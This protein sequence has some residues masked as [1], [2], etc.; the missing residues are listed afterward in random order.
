[1]NV[2]E[3]I[4]QAKRLEIKDNPFSSNGVVERRDVRSLKAALSNPGVSVIA[5]IKMKSPSEGDILPGA[6]PVQIAIDYESAGATAISVLTDTQFFG[7][8]MKT[9]T[10]VREAV[11]IPVL[12]KDFILTSSQILET[13]GS[14]SDALLLIAEAVETTEELKQLH[15]F[16]ESFGMESLVEFHRIENARKM[17]VI[18][19]EIIGVNCRNLETMTTD[20]TH[21]EKV[22][23]LLLEDALKIA[24]SGIENSVDLKYVAD[25]GYDG[26]LVGT[27]LMKTGNPGHAL[28]KLLGGVV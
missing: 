12:R 1:M 3:T 15:T 16:V 6:D 22:F 20:L 13:N 10:Q 25:L 11:S 27:S 23:P 14:E 2:L 8:S 26:A 18:A 7:G 21:F 4:L 9:L 28:E 17:S 5:E 19:P 24:E